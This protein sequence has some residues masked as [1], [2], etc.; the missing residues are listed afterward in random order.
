M[1]KF[2]DLN[3]MEMKEDVDKR[4]EIFLK[5]KK[6][7]MN[8]ALKTNIAICRFFSFLSKNNVNILIKS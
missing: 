5:K 8:A 7:K 6:L 2:F 3:L 4:L 1:K